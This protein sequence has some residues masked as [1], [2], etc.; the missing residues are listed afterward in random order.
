MI[1]KDVRITMYIMSFNSRRMWYCSKHYSFDIMNSVDLPIF[2]Q[3]DINK[4]YR[5]FGVKNGFR[6][7]TV[8]S[9]HG[10]LDDDHIDTLM[11]LSRK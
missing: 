10:S 7:Y 1:G 2:P 4:H 6:Y 3:I 11:D 8:K 9:Y 5:G